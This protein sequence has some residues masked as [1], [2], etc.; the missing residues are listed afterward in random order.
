MLLLKLGIIHVFKTFLLARF[1]RNLLF[2]HIS[3][4]PP[5]AVREQNSGKIGSEN[6]RIYIFIF[7]RFGKKVFM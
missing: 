2:L 3:K 5:N 7:G 6:G 1:L 4:T